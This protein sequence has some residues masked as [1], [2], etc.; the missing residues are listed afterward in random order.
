MAG[1]L[2]CPMVLRLSTPA[3]HRVGALDEPADACQDSRCFVYGGPENCTVN[4][5]HVE[6]VKPHQRTGARWEVDLPCLALPCLASRHTR[7]ALSTL[8]AQAS[9]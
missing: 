7:P 5:V 3:M 1:A 8:A 6:K 4:A 9:I 2:F